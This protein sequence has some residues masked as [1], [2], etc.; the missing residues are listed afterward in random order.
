M[1][2]HDR[3]GGW[4]ICAIADGA[5]VISDFR[6]MSDLRELFGL[7]ASMPTAS[8]TLTEITGTEGTGRTGG[9]SRR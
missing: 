4:R 9:S 3:G 8:R 1:L 6:V 7:M 5:R 2:V